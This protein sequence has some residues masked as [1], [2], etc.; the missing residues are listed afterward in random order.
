MLRAVEVDGN[1]CR[2]EWF[3]DRIIRP[4]TTANPAMTPPLE[5][6]EPG[7]VELTPS[8]MSASGYNE[9]RV[10]FCCSGLSTGRTIENNVS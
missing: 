4:S 10:G 6:K 7:R 8:P 3:A 9:G 5:A 1:G 2:N